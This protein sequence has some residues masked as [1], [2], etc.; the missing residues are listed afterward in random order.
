MSALPTV[1]L[2]FVPWLNEAP[3]AQGNGTEASPFDSHKERLRAAVRRCKRRAR[4]MLRVKK[5]GYTRVAEGPKGDD[6]FDEK[7]EIEEYHEDDG[8]PPWESISGR[9]DPF[10]GRVPRRGILM[11][12]F[13]RITG[14]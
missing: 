1:G 8:I 14:R 7:R 9:D 5:K 11:T 10:K 2:P 6:S 12:A 13:L 3:V 4:E